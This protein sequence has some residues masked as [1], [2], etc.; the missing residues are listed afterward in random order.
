MIVKGN[1]YQEVL[2]AWEEFKRTF[3]GRV[4]IVCY[5]PFHMARMLFIYLANVCSN[6]WIM[7]A[8]RLRDEELNKSL[9]GYLNS[10]EQLIE[11]NN[12]M[13]QLQTDLKELKLLIENDDKENSLAKCDRILMNIKKEVNAK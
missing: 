11:K 7:K 2:S 5:F 12:C 8:A 13:I 6:P 3:V 4:F 10:Q 1:T 9:E